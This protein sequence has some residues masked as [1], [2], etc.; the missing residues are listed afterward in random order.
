MNISPM[1]LLE[2]LELCHHNGDNI[3]KLMQPKVVLHIN[4]QGGI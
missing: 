2:W 3:R 1:M 4:E